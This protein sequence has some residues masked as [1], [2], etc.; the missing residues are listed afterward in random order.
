M[1][2]TDEDKTWINDKLAATETR[3]LTAFHSLT[4]EKLEGMET[5][6]LTAFHQ[7]ASPVEVRQRSHRAAIAALDIE[8]ETLTDRVAK[9]ERGKAS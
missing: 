6:L 5:R 8:V 1:A 7:W 2:L 3:L 9:L 4:D